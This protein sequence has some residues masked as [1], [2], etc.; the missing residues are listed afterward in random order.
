MS[1]GITWGPQALLLEK[2]TRG[3]AQPG[4]VG[5]AREATTVATS[6]ST[7]FIYYF[8]V[9]YSTLCPSKFASQLK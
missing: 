6:L 1:V 9:F 5:N 7:Y 8:S 3:A 2:R 4:N